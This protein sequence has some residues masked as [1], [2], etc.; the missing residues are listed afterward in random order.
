MERAKIREYQKEIFRKNKCASSNFLGDRSL[1]GPGS[2][3][4]ANV[5]QHQHFTK[6]S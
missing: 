3:A 6:V 1:F 4:Q 2:T 5:A